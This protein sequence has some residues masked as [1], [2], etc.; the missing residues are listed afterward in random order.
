M[1]DNDNI[2]EIRNLQINKATQDSDMQI[3]DLNDSSN[4]STFPSL[5]K[6]VNITANVTANI[7]AVH[8]KTRKHQ[9]ITIGLLACYEIF[10]KYIRDLCSSKY[11]NVLNHSFQI[12]KHF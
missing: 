8:K 3:H 2:K 1:K 9:R 10:R 6:L 4:Q 5:L 11:V 12:S 7:T